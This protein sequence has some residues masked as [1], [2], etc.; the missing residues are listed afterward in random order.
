M[1]SKFAQCGQNNIVFK[2][3]RRRREKLKNKPLPF[4]LFYFLG[5][6]QSK[7]YCLIRKSD[8]LEMLILDTSGCIQDLDSLSLS[9][10]HLYK[11]ATFA[12][13]LG[14]KFI[15]GPL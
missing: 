11:L 13:P 7:Q 15:N 8:L 10:P 14:G 1:S 2:A 5:K 3:V 9:S 12:I 4:F 6:S